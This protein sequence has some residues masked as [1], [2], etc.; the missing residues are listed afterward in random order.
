MS[1]PVHVECMQPVELID[2]SNS[3]VLLGVYHFKDNKIAVGQ[4]FYV[5]FNVH[6]LTVSIRG[7]NGPANVGFTALPS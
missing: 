7:S 6:W 3:A 5:L 2:A 1:G 4:V